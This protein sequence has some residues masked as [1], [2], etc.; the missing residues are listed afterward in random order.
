MRI[1]DPSS[2]N[3]RKRQDGMVAV[4]IMFILLGLIV[5]FIVANSS[6]LTDLHNDVKRIEQRQIH[7][8]NSTPAPAVTNS[9][10]TQPVPQ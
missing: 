7:R 5:G 8:I 1:P 10:A 3:A 6:N 4:I 9:P 2:P